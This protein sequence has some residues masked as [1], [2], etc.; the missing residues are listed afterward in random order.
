MVSQVSL[1]ARCSAAGSE[2][3]SVSVR[4]SRPLNSDTSTASVNTLQ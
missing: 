4:S 1:A 2:E 3:R